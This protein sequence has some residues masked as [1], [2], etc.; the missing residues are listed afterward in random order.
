MNNFIVFFRHI[1]PFLITLFLW[2][3]N[4]HFWNPGGILAL[5]PVF[6]YTF[7]RPINWFA[8]FSLLVCF[9]IDYR[10]NLHLFWTSMF[11]LFYAIN[12]FQNYIEIEHLDKNALYIFMLFVGVGLFL[13]MFSAL[14][15]MNF[16]NNI[17]MFIWLSVLYIPI[18]SLD[19]WI[20]R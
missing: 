14:T 4:V 8:G 11:C 9:L 1:A 19:R 3:L 7:V 12:G 6:Y 16:I 20:K 18:T 5:I 10:C 17:W 15:W 13:L 2:R